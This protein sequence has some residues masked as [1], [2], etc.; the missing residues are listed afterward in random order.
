VVG[1]AGTGKTTMLAKALEDLHR[2]TA[3]VF[4]LAPTAKAARVL[5]W[6]TGMAA[7]TVAKLLHEWSRPALEP[8]S[9]YRLPNSTTVVVDEAGMIASHDLARLVMLA[10]HNEWRLVLVGDPRQLQAVGRGGLF[11]ELCRNGRVH[12]LEQIHRFTNRLGGGGV[13]AIAG[14]RPSRP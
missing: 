10:E 5:A 7:D 12:Q 13:A 6:D 14:R 2:H 8:G 11:D 9:P 4:G 1:P 3:P